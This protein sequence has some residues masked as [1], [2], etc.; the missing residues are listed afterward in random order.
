MLVILVTLWTIAAIL[1]LT[2]P[3]SLS[4]RW[5]SALAFFTGFAPFCTVMGTQAIP[6]IQEKWVRDVCWAVNCFMLSFPYLLAPY[7]YLMFCIRYTRALR[8]HKIVSTIL[9]YILL[10]PVFYMYVSTPILPRYR[11]DPLQSTLWVGPYIIV[12][13]IILFYSYFK[14]RNRKLKK[15]IFLTIS[16]L[17]PCALFALL[18]NYFFRIFHIN[19][20]WKY[21]V[22]PGVITFVIFIYGLA[23]FSVMGVRLKPEEQTLEGTM[24]A[25]SSGMA[26]LSHTLKNETAKIS[27]CM[28][29]IKQTIESPEVDINDVNENINVVL[30]S[31]DYL[32]Q[33]TGRLR[34]QIDEISLFEEYT[35]LLQ[36]V[37]TSVGRV[38]L[39]IKQENINVSLLLSSG[40]KIKC[41]QLHIV[42]TITN[43]LKN[44]IE[45]L[46]KGGF[47]E[48]SLYVN[49]KHVNLTI[50]DNGEGIPD[51]YIDRVFEP[52]YSTKS[53]ET[54][55]GLGL[56]YCYNVMKKHNG[57][58]EIFS[59]QGAG[60]TVI[61][62]F[63]KAKLQFEPDNLVP[64]NSI[65]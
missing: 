41:D 51:E 19:S 13:T 7:A 27:I 60:T 30:D 1:I 29:N 53:R 40:I 2:N 28:N 16:V 25:F 43:I 62:S 8:E 38:S 14:E 42:E 12:G 46:G 4:N 21:S 64:C 22:I 26:I 37:E 24:K 33:I 65:N 15:Q 34:K 48:V 44:S 58:M 39:Y 55:F 57:D 52:F 32:S 5:G 10:I 45:A 9:P 18:T 6:L 17:V 36:I 49:K 11:P 56:C 54:N 47:I 23:R 63:P 59:T 35:D 50:S 20:L 61:M 3:K 31:V